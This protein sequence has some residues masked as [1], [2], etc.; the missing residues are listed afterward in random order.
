MR[1][2]KAE[3]FKLRKLKKTYFALIAINMLPITFLFITLY[4]AIFKIG[5]LRQLIS[6]TKIVKD[7]GV[8]S[9]YFI[10]TY[11]MSLAALIFV[12]III[13]ELV[14]KEF[15]SGTIRLFLT[16]PVKRH[17]LY[18]YKFCAVLGF[19][20]I[21]I[22]CGY[23]IIFLNGCVLYFVDK[24]IMSLL[25]Y[26]ALF[27]VSGLF[28]IFDISI[29]S[30]VFLISS[31][32]PTIETTISVSIFLYILMKL[33]DFLL[34]MAQSLNEKFGF[35]VVSPLIS[36]LAPYTY[37]NTTSAVNL[38]KLFAYLSGVTS[39]FPVETGYIFLNLLYTILFFLIGMWIFSKREC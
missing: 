2:I 12:P 15:S 24:S 22:L 8:M 25:N 1:F 17:V 33:I 27:K 31:F 13:G 32:V 16:Q 6:L 9:F 39:T 3:L 29:I 14:A 11:S 5:Q 37:T 36:K 28:I 10:E 23:F 34:S 19:Y 35:K 18:F 30:F 7:K 26:E 38:K 4:L 20:L 21:C